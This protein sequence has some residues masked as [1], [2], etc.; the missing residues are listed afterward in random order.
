M[1]IT[2]ELIE[3][4]T[5]WDNF[6]IIYDG[7]SENLARKFSENLDSLEIDNIL[8]G[9]ED[10][11]ILEDNLNS[12]DCILVISSSGEDE[13]I[14]NMVKPAKSMNVK[15]YAICDKFSDL[16]MLADEI[17]EVDEDFKDSVTENIETTTEKLGKYIKKN[18]RE[19]TTGGIASI[20]PTD[21]RTH[22]ELTLIFLIF[23]G[24]FCLVCTAIM[25]ILNML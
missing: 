23:F 21:F 12:G 11:N 16:A 25:H 19:L 5:S 3:D 6:F 15:V 22:V 18:V 10:S 9:I 2:D 20:Q 1:D 17:I 24:F 13:T 7:E 14:L 8:I 4:I